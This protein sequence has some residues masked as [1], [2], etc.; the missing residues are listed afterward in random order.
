MRAS[1]GAVL[2]VVATAWSCTD[3]PVGPTATATVDPGFLTVEFAAPPAHRDIGVLL[4][5]EGPGI[6]AVRAPG[7][8]LYR[9]EAP[10]RYQVILAGSL[11]SGPLLRF[12]V[13]DRNRLPQYRV[14]VLQVT[15]EDYALRDPAG[16]RAAITR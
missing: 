14:R 3:G 7:L 12:R 2:L 13:P 1:A 4:D 10:G 15:S 8:E 9:S 6:E 5:I 16:Y 11:R